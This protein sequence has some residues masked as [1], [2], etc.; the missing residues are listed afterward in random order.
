MKLASRFIAYRDQLL[1][2][3]IVIPAITGIIL[4]RYS[5]FSLYYWLDQSV[6]D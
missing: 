3:H 4:N 6:V 2:L 5:H 1:L